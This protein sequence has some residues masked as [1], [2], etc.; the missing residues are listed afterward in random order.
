MLKIMFGCGSLYLFSLAPFGSLSDDNWVGMA[1]WV[2]QNIV[3]NHFTDLVFLFVVCLFWLVVLLVAWASSCGLGLKLAHSFV[4]HSHKFW[5]TIAP[6]QPAGKISCGYKNLW[7][8]WQLAFHF[9]QWEPNM[10]TE[11]SQFRL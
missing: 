1:L 6:L 2:Y 4:G 10:V 7:L 3:R 8:S 11:D 9:H 5:A